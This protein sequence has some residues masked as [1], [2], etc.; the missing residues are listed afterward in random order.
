LFAGK[1]RISCVVLAGMTAALLMATVW[2]LRRKD[3]GTG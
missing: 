1:K 2:F 3:V